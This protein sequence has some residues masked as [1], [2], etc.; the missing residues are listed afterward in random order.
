M[1][2]TQTVAMK[3][4]V[5][6][7]QFRPRTVPHIPDNGMPTVR[8]LNAYL[9]FPSGHEQNPHERTFAV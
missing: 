4:H 8:K 1:H 9:M 6:S 5:A 7:V 3:C 2:Q